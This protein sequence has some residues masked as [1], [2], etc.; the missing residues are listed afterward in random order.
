MLLLAA[1]LYYFSW[2]A[3]ISTSCQFWLC[4]Y[5]T[6]YVLESFILG[7]KIFKLLFLVYQSP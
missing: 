4:M 7:R 3:S 1:W 2:C 6:L 5:N